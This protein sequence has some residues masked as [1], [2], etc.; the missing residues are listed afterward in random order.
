MLVVIFRS[1]IILVFLI[2]GMR[3]MGKRTIGEYQPFEFVIVLAVAELAATPMQDISTPIIYGL[4]PLITVFVVHFILSSINK[5]SIRL[6]KFL[7]GKPMIVIDKDGIN[8]Q[9]LKELNM[10]TDDLMGM[11]RGQ[12]CFSIEEVNYAIMET[13]GKLSIMQNENAPGSQSI[14]MSV[15]VEGKIMGENIKNINLDKQKILDIIREKNL[16]LN[17]VLL[18]TL[19]SKKVFIQPI[20]GKYMTFEAQDV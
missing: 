11:L 10:N 7:N 8:S 2:A 19:D 9:A 14:P 18:M 1:L 13:N 5:K 3:L 4:V 6:R 16:K 15:V 17:E 20:N 12:G